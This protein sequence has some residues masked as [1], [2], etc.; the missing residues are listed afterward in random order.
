MIA[1]LERVLTLRPG[2]LGRGVL[3]YLYLF[4]VIA[5]YT[6]GKVAR[7]ALFLDRFDAVKLPMADLASALLVGVVVAG[8]LAVARRVTLRNLLVGCLFLYSATCVLFWYLVHFHQQPWLF[9]VFYIWVGIFGVLAPMQVWKLANFVLTTREAKRIFGL[10]GAGAISGWIFGGFASRVTVKAYGTEGLLMGMAVCLA[11]CAGLV[12]P[13]WRRKQLNP[14]ESGTHE[15]EAQPTVLESLRQIAA[16]PYLIAIAAVIC[17]SSF[18]TTFAGWQFKAIAK[19][20]VPQKDAL[21]LFFSDFNFI[22]GIACLLTQMLLTSRA[23]RRFGL[24]FTLYVVPV[25]LL[26]GTIG[27]LAFGTLVAAVLLK[28]SDQVLRY[29]IDKSSVEL[30]YLPLAADLKLRVK[31]FI[32]T[33]IWRL[34]DGLAALTLVLFADRLRFGAREVGWVNL[35]FIGGWLVAAFFARKQ[36]VHTLR[37]SIRRHR[38]DVEH[39]D[40]PVLDRSTA[41]IFSDRFVSTDPKEILYALSLFEAE[42]RRRVHPAVRGLL[43]HPAAEVRRKALALQAEAGDRL[44]VPEVEGLLRDPDFEVRTEALLYL[45]HHAHIDPLH[46]IEE[47]G[48]FPDFSIRSAMAAFLARP[49]DTQNL[50]AAT[51]ILDAMIDEPGTQGA[52]SR[53]EAAR[54]LQ[55]VEGPFDAHLERLVK[56]SDA[57]VRRHALRAIGRQRCRRLLPTVIERLTDPALSNDA[58]EALALFGDSIVGTLRDYLGDPAQ[59][60]ELRA[61]IAH[62]LARIGTPAAGRALME[63]LLE[64]ETNLRFLILSSLNKLRDAHPGLEL[65]TLLLESV[66]AAEIMGH[67]R[68]YQILN[69]LGENLDDRDA[70]SSALR[71]S[72]RQEVERIFRLLTLLHPGYDFHSAYVGLQSSN[73]VVHD[74]ALEFLDNVL[75]PA[76]RNTLVPL[77]D[78][79]VSVAERASL[80]ARL[81]HAGVETREAAVAELVSSDDPWLKACGAYA[82]GTLRLTSLVAQLESCLNHPDPLLRETARQ[83]KVRLSAQSGAPAAD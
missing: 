82:I 71:E 41:E 50:E 19:Q 45:A 46:K 13:I 2:D 53:R 47:L 65:D 7:D 1:Y 57:D 21:A 61:S 52:R 34:G 56:D 17:M 15:A 67:Y 16:S 55:V 33:F 11:I 59:S 9:P 29:S 54:L 5:S 79:E 30:L 31:S 8:Y 63:N 20:F 78:S 38:M 32:D 26:G 44:V 12:V 62:A 18:V 37:D 4:L 69:T 40:T 49:G 36:Y 80:G 58:A 23:L 27:V 3:L 43:Y 72:M 51:R 74:N 70:V 22:A 81:C 48:D 14:L 83:A 75:K 42:R 10:V 77:L 25:A 68:S 35:V 28:G 24:G 73:A 66:L 6:I 39:I 76:L 64:R 60:T